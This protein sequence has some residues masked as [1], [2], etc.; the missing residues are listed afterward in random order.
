MH[1]C[2]SACVG[3]WVCMYA[4]QETGLV[5]EWSRRNNPHLTCVYSLSLGKLLPNRMNGSISHGLRVLSS[6]SSD[7][8]PLPGGGDSSPSWSWRYCFSISRAA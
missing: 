7:S 5:K 1:V 3:V 8:S 2:V 4:D 6:L